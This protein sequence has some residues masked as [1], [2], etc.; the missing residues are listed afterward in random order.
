MGSEASPSFQDL[1]F[2]AMHNWWNFE[3]VF[4]SKPDYSYDE[5][6]ANAILKNRKELAGTLFFDRVW[7]NLGLKDGEFVV[8]VP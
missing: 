6:T 5:K 4:Q 7:A 1:L 3:V 2:L 8:N